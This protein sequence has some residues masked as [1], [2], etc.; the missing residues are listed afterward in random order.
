MLTGRLAS[1]MVSHYGHRAVCLC[2]G[3]LSSFGL[4]LASYST[5]IW[6][7]YISYGV[8]GGKTNI[9][10][11]Y[12]ESLFSIA[13]NTLNYVLCI[14]IISPRVILVIQEPVGFMV[15]TMMPNHSDYDV[16]LLFMFAGV[17]VSFI[18]VP[19]AVVCS[20]YFDRLRPLALGI[21]TSGVGLFCLLIPPLLRLAITHYGWRNAMVLMSALCIQSCLFSYLLLPI[22]YW[23]RPQRLKQQHSSK[24]I[25]EI[26]DSQNID[27]SALATKGEKSHLNKLTKYLFSVFDLELLCDVKF[28][29]FFFNNILWNVSSLIMLV[30]VTDF[31][32]VSHMKSSKGPWLISIIGLSGIVG[33]AGSGAISN[34][35][36]VNRFW[37]YNIATALSAFTIGGLP[38]YLNFGYFAFLCALYGLCFGAQ[39]GVLAVAITELFGVNKL[40]MAYGYI[41]VAHGLGALCGPPLGGLLFEETQGYQVPF[42]FAGAISML[43]AL[44]ACVIPIIDRCSDQASYAEVCLQEVRVTT[45]ASTD[46]V[47]S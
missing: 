9:M 17:G 29:V 39:C 36:Y 31:A 35:P 8:L 12:Q 15:C 45:V 41:M 34:L 11:N 43:T 26:L 27:I 40:S 5:Q 13:I 32:H 1:L 21:G 37:V 7:L 28:I 10:I 23:Q 16:L 24:K 30:M 22:D 33:R 6:H 38:L 42:Y 2:G 25:A 14:V 4:L 46:D 3:L 44:L 19:A 18:F 20:T 47:K